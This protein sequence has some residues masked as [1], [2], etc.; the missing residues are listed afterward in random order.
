M[1]RDTLHNVITVQHDKV[2]VVDFGSKVTQLIARRVREAGVYCEIAPVQNAE[3]TFAE[4]APKSVIRS[5]GP[6]SV[7]DQDAPRVPDA[8]F[9][10]GVPVLGISAAPMSRF[11]NIAHCSKEY[12]EKGKRYLVSMSHGDAVTELPP[13]FSRI[14]A[15]EHAPRQPYESV[16]SLDLIHRPLSDFARHLTSQA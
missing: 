1:A 9:A 10:A 16:K 15:S 3:K 11:C 5:G 4:L 13:G 12:G 2:F 8:L 6:A 7:H 14:A